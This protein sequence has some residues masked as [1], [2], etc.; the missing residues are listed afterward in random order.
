V[1]VSCG[2]AAAMVIAPLGPQEEEEEEEEEEEDEVVTELAS[3]EVSLDELAA[4]EL[5]SGVSVRGFESSE[6]VTEWGISIGGSAGL[7]DGGGVMKAQKLA[8][9]RE[10]EFGIRNNMGM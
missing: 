10:Y 4:W 6:S 2:V 9:T 7:V 3:L 5:C 8:R 1:R